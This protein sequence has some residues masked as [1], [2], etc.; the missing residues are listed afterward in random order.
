MIRPAAGRR[1]REPRCEREGMK[2]DISLTMDEWMLVKLTA[3]R[4]MKASNGHAFMTI[5]KT[6]CQH[7]GRSPRAAGR[8]RG[9]FMTF[10]G[11]LDTILLNIE[12]ERAEWK[13]AAPAA[14]TEPA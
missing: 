2:G 9:W 3:D 7:C 8:C 12:Q 6:R 11:H 1:E 5:L 13:A 10:L 4:R 14:D